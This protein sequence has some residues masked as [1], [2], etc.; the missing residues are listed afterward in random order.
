MTVELIAWAGW[1]AALGVSLLALMLRARVFELQAK[2]KGKQA[3]IESLKWT[4][5]DEG[6]VNVIDD[7]RPRS[8]DDWLRDH[9]GTDP[10]AQRVQ[11]DRL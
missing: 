1:L 2:L 5:Q 8:V 9:P 6:D 7:P 10:I 4:K 3:V 11:H